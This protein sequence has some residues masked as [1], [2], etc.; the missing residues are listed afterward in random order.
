MHKLIEYVC[1]ELKDLEKKVEKGGKLSLPEIQYADTLAHLKKSILTA[2]A[3]DTYK[4]DE[5]SYRGYSRMR[6]ANRGSYENANR[7]SYENPNRT[8][9]EMSNRG[10]Y[11][12]YSRNAKDELLEELRNLQRHAKNP[13][14]VQMLSEWIRQMEG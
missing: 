9:Y 5:G 11:A 3:M 6:Y 13:D 12:N 1:D 4:E 2:D 8:D 7:G 14:S 10:S